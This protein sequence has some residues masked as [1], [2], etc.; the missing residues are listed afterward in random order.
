MNKRVRRSFP[1][2]HGFTVTHS[3]E[4]LSLEWMLGL[5]FG[6]SQQLLTT[7][8][9]L[10]CDHV[11]ILLLETPFSAAFHQPEPAFSFLLLLPLFS[12]CLWPGPDVFLTGISG[13]LQGA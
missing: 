13:C 2:R 11:A 4:A 3:Q 7:A 1:S 8:Q 5:T 6:H 9:A 10:R 12:P